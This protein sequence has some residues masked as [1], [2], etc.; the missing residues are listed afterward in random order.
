MAL[1]RVE[2]VA[3]AYGTPPK[4][5]LCDVSTEVHEG[6]FVC[7]LGETGCGKSTLLRLILGSEQPASS[8]RSSPHPVKY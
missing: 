6:E 3:V 1:I 7:V 5:V 2:N 4:A 8:D